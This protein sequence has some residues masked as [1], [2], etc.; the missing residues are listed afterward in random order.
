MFIRF[1][2]SELFKFNCSN[3]GQFRQDSLPNAIIPNAKILN[4]I[5]PNAIIPNVL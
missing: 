2:F 1:Y 4:A 3:D 5:I